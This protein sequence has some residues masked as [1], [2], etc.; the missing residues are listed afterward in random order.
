ME[1]G[2]RGRKV[3]SII[4]ITAG[5]YLTFRFLLPLVIPFLIAWLG[6]GIMAPAVRILEKKLRMKRSLA[7]VLVGLLFF[8]FLGTVGLWLVHKLLEELG[9]LTCSLGNLEKLLNERLRYFC[10]EVEGNFGL[11]PDTLYFAAA[12]GMMRL[13][14]TVEEKAM[15]L[16]MSNSLPIVKALFEGIAVVF[17]TLISMLMI[18][19]DYDI[20]QEKRGQF[21]FAQ[22]LDG[23]LKKVSGAMGAYFKTQGILILITSAISVAGLFVLNNSYALLFGISIGVLDAL[24]FVG[25]G[26]IYLPWAVLA[27][28]MGDWR[29][30]VC[31]LF[32]YGACYL[33]RELLEPRLMGKQI[34][35]TSLE[36]IISMYVGIRLLGL[37]GVLLGPIG[38]LMI[39]ELFHS[40]CGK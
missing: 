11:Q 23:I 27:G 16:V 18:C 38:Y 15:P 14:S 2:S 26:I 12:S 22:E 32:I 36:M 21:M 6:A 35:M 4:G 34:G 24:P 10:G 1:A 25:T 31:V 29:H 33:V 37:S 28:A 5:V 20:L 39:V 19:K 30:C 40:F 9:S 13:I 3:V 7:V 8:S 17:I